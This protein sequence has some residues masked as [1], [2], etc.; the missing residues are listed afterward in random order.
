M[1]TL[2]LMALPIVIRTSEEALLA[3]PPA[4]WETA[5]GLG[6]TRLQ[7]VA[8]ALRL[9]LPQVLTGLILSL[10]RVTGETAPV[11][12]TVAAYYVNFYPVTVFDQTMLL[13]YHVYALSTQHP[14]LAAARPS[15][16]GAALTLMV[17]VFLFNL[18]AH[19]IRSY[20]TQRYSH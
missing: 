5:Y 16:F 20:Y 13:S 4:V 17:F 15:V 8:V 3:V 1:C 6:A 10:S 11:L 19:V 9:A 2:A 18:A 7:A 14:D 12:F